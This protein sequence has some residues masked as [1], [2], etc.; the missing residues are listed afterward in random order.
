M[1]SFVRLEI[2]N[3]V[4]IRVFAGV[5][6][7]AGLALPAT[8]ADDKSIASVETYGLHGVAQKTI[9]D[10]AGLRVGGA[11]PVSRKQQQAI[12]QRLEKV[13]GVRRAALVVVT[14]PYPAGTGAVGTGGAVPRP[15][16]YIG[17]QEAGR[18]D[19]AFRAAPSGNVSLPKAILDTYA[20]FG[21][22]FL[23]SIEHGDFSEDDSN[24]YALLG[25]EAARTV[26]RKFVGPAN[27]HYDLLID[28]LRNAKDGNQ[29][30]MAAWI[31]AY[32]N[33]KKRVAADLIIGTRDP[34]GEV[35]NNAMRGLSVLIGYA[36]K[37]RDLELYVPTDWCLDLLESL[38]WTDRNK[39]MAVLD[40]I[41]VD[42]HA[43]IYPKLQQRSL[44]TLIEMARWKFAGH[45]VMAFELVGRL[46]G[47]SDPEI[48]KAWDAGQ[49]EQVI[50]RALQTKSTDPAPAQNKANSN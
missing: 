14:V 17:V 34:N 13:P 32:A 19:V 21:R 27:Q 47:L 50:S 15:I 45:A 24:G 39:V 20:D 42:R 40:E 28:V 30:A 16:V 22:A 35:R 9:L 37:H 25:D 8:A 36:R 49:R 4:A 6:I 44:P 41:T 5:L 48:F 7:I 2:N 43:A 3:V 29:R 33:D 1:N 46:A 23:K 18:L 11:A 10:A 26:Q 12:I 38:E 31:I